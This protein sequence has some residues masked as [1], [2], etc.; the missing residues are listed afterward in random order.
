MGIAWIN[1]NMQPAT[2]ADLLPSTMADELDFCRLDS[3]PPS[4]AALQGLVAQMRR[5]VLW[6]I[7]SKQ[8]RMVEV[9]QA[10]MS[11]SNPGTLLSLPHPKLTCCSP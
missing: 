5:N 7:L 1:A 2:P 9:M 8:E 11:M 3:Q 10:I 4:S 6:Q